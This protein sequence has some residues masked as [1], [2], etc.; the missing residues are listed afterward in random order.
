[1]LH[2][3]SYASYLIIFLFSAS[4]SVLFYIYIL[5]TSFP[6]ALPPQPSLLQPQRSEKVVQLCLAAETPSEAP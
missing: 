6:A 4:P 3:I 2:Y 5:H 1:M